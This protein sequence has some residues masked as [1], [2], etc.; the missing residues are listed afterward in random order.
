M[1]GL[2]CGIPSSGAWEIL[3]NGVDAAI[4]IEDDYARKAVRE[5]YYPLGGDQQIISGESGAGGVAALIAIMED[6]RYKDLRASINI[7]KRSRILSFRD[8]SMVWATWD[9]KSVSRFLATRII[10][11]QC[12]LCAR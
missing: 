9:P 11:T 10:A 3:K 7:S 4:R 6:Q 8:N 1:S 5:L 2:N 12:C